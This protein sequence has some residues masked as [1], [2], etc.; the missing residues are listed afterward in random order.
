MGEKIVED[1]LDDVGV[2]YFL[3]E[4][5]HEG[6]GYETEESYFDLFWLAVVEYFLY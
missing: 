6:E 3:D 2:E 4:L 5:L 1:V